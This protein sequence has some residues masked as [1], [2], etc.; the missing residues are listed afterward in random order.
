MEDI[1]PSEYFNELKSKLTVVQLSDLENQIAAISDKILTAKKLGQKNMLHKLAFVRNTIIKEQVLLSNGLSTYV[2]KDD[3]VRFI[4]NVVPRNSVKIIELE[5]FP[6]VIPQD[7]A[8]TI[9]KYKELFDSICI[10]FTD[11][12]DNEYKSEEDKAVISRNRDPI[13]FGYFKHDKA[14][15]RHERFYYITDWED[16][17]CDLT[18]TK[19]VEKL[20]EMGIKDVVKDIDTSSYIDEIV[21]ESIEELEE[22]SDPR[23]LHTFQR[24]EP[25]NFITKFFNLFK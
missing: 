11:F 7:N 8:D 17:Y 25:E 4:E 15:L 13:A 1:E 20:G 16:E 21:R 14:N 10:V 12:T 2:Y 18:L 3:I 9:L 22:I 5:R 24:K 6:R 19:L 23:T